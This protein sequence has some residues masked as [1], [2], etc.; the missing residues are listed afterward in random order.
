MRTGGVVRI[1]VPDLKNVVAMY[2]DESFLDGE[3]IVADV[4]EPTASEAV[5]LFGSSYGTRGERL[6]VCMYGWGHAYLYDEEDLIRLLE[7]AGFSD[8]RRQRHLMSDHAPLHRVETRPPL[9]SALIV[10]GIKR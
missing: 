6:N 1:S 9:Q 5:A 2:C 8:V 10:E 3:N 7:E 4:I